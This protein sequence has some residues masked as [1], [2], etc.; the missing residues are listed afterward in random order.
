VAQLHGVHNIGTRAI[1]KDRLRRSSHR[2]GTRR[3]H[4]LRRIVDHD[5]QR[6]LLQQIV[7]INSAGGACAGG[8][9]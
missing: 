2:D 9:V 4:A 3:V 8:G 6:H 7:A 5:P 1:D